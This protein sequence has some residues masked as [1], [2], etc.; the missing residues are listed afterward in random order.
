MA[1]F[2][3]IGLSIYVFLNKRERQK[4]ATIFDTHIEDLPTGNLNTKMT[5]QMLLETS[6]QVWQVL[7]RK[8]KL[9][10]GLNQVI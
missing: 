5:K 6:L 10:N 3:F 4:I 1:T 2:A 9:V 7:R 8:L